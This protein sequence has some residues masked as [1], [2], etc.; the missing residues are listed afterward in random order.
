MVWALTNEL[1]FLEYRGCPREESRWLRISPAQG[2]VMLQ[3]LPHVSICCDRHSY[4]LGASGMLTVRALGRWP[5]Q[6]QV[7]RNT[8]P[9]LYV[10]CCR[11]VSARLWSRALGIPHPLSVNAGWTIEAPSP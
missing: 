5:G 4:V 1:S 7:V 9:Q 8:G 6:G 2:S 10:P 3:Q 11:P